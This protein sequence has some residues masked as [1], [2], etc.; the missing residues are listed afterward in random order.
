MD[1]KGLSDLYHDAT[2][3]LTDNK[4]SFYTWILD[5]NTK[6]YQGQ[7]CE[8][9]VWYEEKDRWYLVEDGFNPFD[10]ANT[11]WL[12]KPVRGDSLPQPRQTV[13]KHFNL[14]KE[15]HLL[16]INCKKR[17]VLLLQEYNNDWVNVPG[18][19][20]TRKTWLCLPIFSYKDDRHNQSYV[21]DDEAFKTRSRFY[22]PLSCNTC[23][24]MTKESCIRID[25]LQVIQEESLS[26]IKML[27]NIP[28]VNMSKRF[29]VSDF[30]LTM[31]IKHLLLHLN[32]TLNKSYKDEYYDLFVEYCSEIIAKTLAGK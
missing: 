32:L 10:E 1:K 9:L 19:K 22:M 28:S 30:G 8:S 26:P 17:P 5:N 20:S 2:Q 21:L 7:I 23:P 15:E 16:A 24:G 18:Q 11:S 12:A 27:C 14:E 25:A 6:L 29:R 4:E 3:F 13:L 31:I